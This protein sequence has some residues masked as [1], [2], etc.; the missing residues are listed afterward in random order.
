[1][2]SLCAPC[3]RELSAVGP[4]P[5][6][7]TAIHRPVMLA[8]VARA[9]ALPVGGVM[10][11]ATVGLGGHASAIL[12]ANPTIRLIGIDCD[13]KALVVT[14]ERLRCYGERA[15]C[16]QGNFS[17]LPDLLDSMHVTQ[18]EGLLVDL[19]VSSMQ[20]EDAERGFSFLHAG[21]LDM[22]MDQRQTKTAADLLHTLSP[23]QLVALLRQYG[24]EPYAERIARAICLARRQAPLQGTREL[25]Q[26][27]TRTVP[28]RGQ[29]LHPAT[30]TFQALRMAVNDEPT[31]LERFLAV[32]P[33]RLTP[34][35]RLVCLAF[36]SIEDR[37]VKQA[38]QRYGHGFAAVT[39]KPLRPTLQEIQ[40]NPRAR[41]AR[42]R[43]LQ[44]L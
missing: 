10:V 38:F 44:R 13:E 33:P 18:I 7:L 39:K 17:E 24:E 29:R 25:A 8:E 41:S 9:L 42:L 4:T 11:D 16:L 21:P 5:R 22:R 43:V 14:K 28:R 23:Q 19:G 27:I 12:E 20:L 6:A 32:G 3:G 2:A 26:L 30:R 31:Y 15:V 40:V 37:L 36:H 35:G 1:M 34:G